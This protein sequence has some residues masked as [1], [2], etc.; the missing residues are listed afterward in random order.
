MKTLSS[1]TS[2][3]VAL[4]LAC[5]LAFAADTAKDEKPIK[6]QTTCPVMGGKINKKLY[7]D[8]GGK[9]IYVCCAGCL[10]PLKKAAKEHIAKLE[11]KGITLDKTPPA[12]CT[13]CGEVKGTA[14]CCKAEGRTKCSKCELFKGS[15]GCC[16]IP[17]GTKKPVPLCTACGEIKGA[18]PC[19]KVEG[20]TK[21][22]KC[23]LLEGSTGCCKLP[24]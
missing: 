3:L 10:K 9:R 18:A 8:H 22:S 15:P 20:R 1:V 16:K 4:A 17:K 19:C 5:S 6:P 21:C 12:L 11:A 13:G 14:K 24:R 2:V 7:V 23:N